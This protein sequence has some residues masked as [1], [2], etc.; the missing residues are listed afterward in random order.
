[1]K[2]TLRIMA[3][4]ST[5]LLASCTVVGPKHTPPELA[6]IT[7]KAPAW[8]APLPHA[9]DAQSLKAWWASWNDPALVALIDAT[10]ANNPTLEQASARISQ[11]RISA[12]IAGSSALPEAS[13][14]SGLTRGAQGGPTATNWS[15]TAQTAWE[16]DLFGGKVRTR[17]SS[18][19]RIQ[20]R[21]VDWH[22]ARVSLAAEVA[23][24]Y[25][26][27]RVN[28]ALAV[29]FEQD[30]VS[31]AE[32]ARLTQ[33][34]T[35]A[36][37]EAPAN[38]ALAN[39]AVSDAY[40]RI[41][42]Q[43][44]EID[45]AIKGLVGL[46]GLA[47]PEVRKLLTPARASLPTVR[48]LAVSNVPAQALT[49]RPDLAGL[50]REL[51]ALTAEIGIAEADRYPKISF[52]GSIGY[53]ISRALGTTTDGALWGFGPSISIPLFDSGRRAANVELAVARHQ[54]VAASY[55]GLAM[56]A[57]RETEEALTRL[58]AAQLREPDLRASVTGYEA[59]ARAAQA[60]LSAGVGSV[61]EL[62][63]ARRAVLGAQVA[64]LNLE[65]DRLLAWIALYRAVGGGWDATETVKG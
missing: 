49:Q 53:S 11:A 34:K 3:V 2:K 18:E 10:Q 42:A 48:G 38:A 29:G 28:E 19:A 26:S 9:G 39:A 33:L 44:A 7:V 6:K 24:I 23:S 36:G 20:A 25:A 41:I 63:D 59:F 31:R 22:E 12:R 47:E 40:A 37:F 14:G 57:V 60:R 15:T 16:L 27:L 51:A 13:G 1:M 35:N 56:R 32:T 64:V 21:S 30:R 52:S 46:C 55:K 45:L 61:L 43:Q 58:N 50:E 8:N 4:V 17:E 5:V 62:E 65:R 54:E